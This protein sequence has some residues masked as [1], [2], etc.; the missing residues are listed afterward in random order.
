MDAQSWIEWSRD[1]DEGVDHAWVLVHHTREARI[2]NPRR[3]S[4]HLDGEEYVTLLR[5]LEECVA[6]ARAIVRTVDQS[7]QAPDEWG[8]LFRDAW[9]P[10]L[11]A[12]CERL[13]SPGADVASLRPDLKGLVRDL[14]HGELAGEHW[15]VYGSLIDSTLNIIDVVDDVA[16]SREVRT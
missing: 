9:L 1:A 16:S 12:V 6:Q 11:E 14:S 4:R 2:G 15:P 3:S 5:R 10:L 7:N 8:A 13:V